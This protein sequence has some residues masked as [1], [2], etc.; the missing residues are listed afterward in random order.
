M[1][2]RVRCP[3]CW[4]TAEVPEDALGKVGKCNTCG[5][6]VRIPERLTKVCFICGTDV[7]NAPHA[8]DADRNYLCQRCWQA[9]NRKQQ[10]EFGIPTLECSVCLAP[11]AEEDAY[12]HDGKIVCKDCR[13]RLQAQSQPP[14]PLAEI[15]PPAPV[16]PLVSVHLDATQDQHPHEHDHVDLG[17]TTPASRSDEPRRQP[18]YITRTSLVPSFLA[19]LALA[20]AAFLAYRQFRPPNWEDQNRARILALKTHAELLVDVGQVQAGLAKYDDLFALVN[21]R[22]LLSPDLKAELEAARLSARIAS[23]F[24]PDTWEQDNH[25]RILV[26]RGQGDVLATVG[27]SSDAV[28]KYQQLFQLVGTRQ[29]R[30][31]ILQAELRQ[32]RAA[33]DRLRNQAVAVQPIPASLPNP[34]P[35]TAPVASV[36]GTDPNAKPQPPATKPIQP[37][38]QVGSIPQ[39]PPDQPKR[40]IKSIFDD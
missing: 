19:F 36:Q 28:E 33:F 6:E 10:E 1:A 4:T 39:V 32:A 34:G 25:A 14:Q 5:A 3:R 15:P 20:A 9:R 35:A 16:P 31:P 29:L 17:L 30:N 40:E 11:L 37:P 12:S 27:K 2:I 7:T 13:S 38:D 23:G 22:L 8:K 24:V 18:V 26:L 21:G